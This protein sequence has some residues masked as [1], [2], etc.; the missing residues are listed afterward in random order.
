MIVDD[1]HARDVAQRVG[2]RAV[3]ALADVAVGDHL[4]DRGRL[5]EG[6]LRAGRG[7]RHAEELL[8]RDV[9][10][11]V[12]V[13]AGVVFGFVGLRLRLRLR[14]RIRCRFRFRVRYRVRFRFR[15]RFGF[16]LR[17]K[18]GGAGVVLRGGVQGDAREEGEDQGRVREVLHGQG[19]ASGCQQPTVWMLPERIVH[20]STLLT[21][22]PF[23]SRSTGPEAPS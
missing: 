12:H 7:D 8:E 14:F 11:G 9:L 23:S 6:H 19:V 15:F 10:D 3:A 22:S 1:V 20:S 13:E 4:D 18:R 5:L 2:H 16:R 17:F 21:G